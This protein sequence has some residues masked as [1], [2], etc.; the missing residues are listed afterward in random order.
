VPRVPVHDADGVVDGPVKASAPQQP[1]RL[2]RECA[3]DPIGRDKAREA[4]QQAAAWMAA[5]P[6]DEEL[7][8]LRA[9]ARDLLGITD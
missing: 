4:Y 6:P 2:H 3:D 8:Q 5:D 1:Y 9:E 7:K